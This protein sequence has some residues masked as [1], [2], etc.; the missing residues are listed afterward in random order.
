M[1]SESPNNESPG[2]GKIPL[3]K[4][5]DFIWIPLIYAFL[6]ANERKI[7]VNIIKFDL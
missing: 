1:Y 2:Q 6:E 4:M 3:T 5:S 7:L